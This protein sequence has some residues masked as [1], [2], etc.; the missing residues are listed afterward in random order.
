VSA[1]YELRVRGRL[2]GALAAE[3]ARM[4]LDVRELPPTTRLHGEVED[5]T[6]LYGLLRQIEGLGL[7]VVDV[8][9]VSLDE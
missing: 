2:S 8:R 5:Q 3:F 6:A 7:E 9:R 4:R 1:I